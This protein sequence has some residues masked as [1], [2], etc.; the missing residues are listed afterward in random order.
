MKVERQAN[1]VK[2]YD[3]IVAGGGVAG[4]A[5]A[6]SAKRMGKS[7][8]IIEKKRLVWEARHFGTYQYFCSYV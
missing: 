4:V 2:D 1:H 6:V 7:V 8:L 5:A 3:I